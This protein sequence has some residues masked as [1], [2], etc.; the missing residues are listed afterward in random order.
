[1]VQNDYILQLNEDID[2][3]L[4]QY[5]DSDV[6]YLYSVFDVN[7]DAKNRLSVL[8]N[9]MIWES[10]LEPL[11]KVGLSDDYCI[12][13]IKLDKYGKL[14]ESM[15]FPVFKYCELADEEWETST[16][17]KMFSDTVFV[18]VVFK[19]EGKELFLN[20]IKIWKMPQNV[21]DG[22]VKDAWS[23]MKECICSGTIV[24]YIDDHGKYFTYFPSSTENQY[25]HVRPH[26]QNRDDTYPLPV[27]DKL[28]G[29]VKY[30]KHSFWLNRAYVLKI[31]NGE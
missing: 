10:D 31:I 15:S 24:K 1:M 6:D 28:T 19:N 25:V 18:F 4:E 23:K 16:L 9:K 12:K 5:K 8:I 27:P 11:K 30:P 3:F 14:K 7:P 13:T 20:R 21:L 2:S 26:A 17:H 22:G 29:L